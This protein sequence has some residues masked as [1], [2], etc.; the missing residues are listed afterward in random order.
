VEPDTTH[1]FNLFRIKDA[2][3]QLRDSAAG[4]APAVLIYQRWPQHG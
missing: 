1:C 2:N 4:G 3:G